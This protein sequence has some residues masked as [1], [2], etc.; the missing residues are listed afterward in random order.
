MDGNTNRTWHYNDLNSNNRTNDTGSNEWWEVD[1]GK[2]FPIERI[3][4]W[5]CEG[6]EISLVG[7]RIV[8]L[9]EDRKVLCEIPLMREE[10][11]LYDFTATAAYFDTQLEMKAAQELQAYLGK[12]TGTEFPIV[13]YGQ[14]A[15]KGIPIFVGRCAAKELG[16]DPSKLTATDWILE[17]RNGAVHLAGSKLDHAVNYFIENMLGVRWWSEKEEY[18]PF[19]P[20]LKVDP[21]A[22]R[23]NP[24]FKI[25]NSLGD[26][27]RWLAR[28]RLTAQS[29]VLDGNFAH[30]TLQ[31]L[32]PV[33]YHSQH[34]EWYAE[35]DGV[36]SA[37]ARDYCMTAEGLPEAYA[38][39]LDAV[40]EEHKKMN[41]RRNI[42]GYMGREDGAVWC[43]CANCRAYYEK[44]SKSDLYLEFVNKVAA[45]VEPRHP[46]ILILYSAYQEA[47]SPPKTQK[48][49]DN[50]IPWYCT[51]AQNISA[52]I[53]DPSNTRV[54]DTI[55]AWAAISKHMGFWHYT[56]SF[57]R[58]Q[59]SY[60]VG[61]STL[62]NGFD[63]P[64]DSVPHFQTFLQTLYGMGV[65]NIAIQNNDN[66]LSRDT[67]VMKTWMMYKLME[68][69]F[70]DYDRLLA[71]FTNGY[72]GPA[73]ALVRDYLHLLRQ[74]QEKHPSN[75]WFYADQL[76]YRYLTLEFCGE[77]DA[78]LAA[79]ETET[80]K[81]QGPYLD[82][83]RYLRACTVDRVFLF[84]WPIFM[85]EWKL[86]GKE[87]ASFPARVAELLERAKR[88]GEW[89]GKVLGQEPLDAE[90]ETVCY[91]K[92]AERIVQGWVDLPML[93]RFAEKPPAAVFQFAP[94]SDAFDMVSGAPAG[95]IPT[96]DAPT[97]KATVVLL[98][99]PTAA[100]GQAFRIEG[101]GDYL[102]IR[103]IGRWGDN[104]Q[105]PEKKELAQLKSDEWQPILLG[106]YTFDSSNNG[107]EIAVGTAA[108]KFWA[109]A[110]EPGTY[111]VWL[112]AK[113]AP[114]KEGLSVL[115]VE[116]LIAL[117]HDGRLL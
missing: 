20:D 68:N 4:V 59:G 104:N 26:S 14:Q 101:A 100:S 56:R 46:N 22:L 110:M 75:I 27:K 70:L 98:E 31:I 62:M 29:Q 28:N 99:D 97:R 30:G 69:P 85:R 32:P 43:E 76:E 33:K 16:V 84:K 109:S 36:R 6:N 35:K 45:L 89:R 21:V 86:Q 65:R 63:Y 7:V 77:A 92:Y 18:V 60:S 102:T 25:R 94:Q 107:L 34:P 112:H 71:D 64:V 23:F 105:N 79:A 67:F 116:R 90:K 113:T 61:G 51:E 2:A 41:I 114:V 38:R 93:P 42:I 55:K 12:V 103:F 57:E 47:S 95:M 3:K 54:L 83:V 37:T 53:I 40:I 78:I 96:A 5:T 72:Y 73:G 24:A 9:N 19:R 81:T 74:H 106:E 108:F 39:E 80:A 87:P 17:T 66:F 44:H 111:E 15:G 8:L 88:A 117:R 58:R 115:L 11:R 52:S 50:V 1:L 49:R 91:L 10:K 82:R 13:R 48:P